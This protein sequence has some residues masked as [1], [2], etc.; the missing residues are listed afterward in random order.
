VSA[1]LRLT[2]SYAGFLVIAGIALIALVFYILQYV[3]DSG[4]LSDNGAFI[5]NRG[6]LLAAL[7][8]RT[9]QLIV[10]LALIGVVGGW[11]LAG[12]M[13]RPLDRINAVAR[14]VDAGAFDHRVHLRGRKDEFSELADTFD[15]M[16][17][18]L[19]GSFE[20]QRRFAANAAHELRTPYAIERSML[21]VAL[22][23][24]AHVD[25]D[26]LLR[27]LDETN[28]RG[29]EVVE[30]LLALASIDDGR[31]LPRSPVD[32]TETVAAVIRE[33][34]PLADAAGVTVVAELGECDIDGSPPLVR[35]LASNLILNGIRHNVEKDGWI[36]VRTT[37]ESD[38]AVEL[39]VSNSGPTVPPELLGR[40]TEP[41][42][43]GVSR[44]GT[45]ANSTKGSLEGTGLGLALVSRVA[46]VHGA[47]LALAAPETGGLIATVRFLA[48]G[49]TKSS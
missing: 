16:L 38:G 33:L 48:P 14:R 42:V 36:A 31:E 39:S 34:R 41:F 8:P 22:S 27:R 17:D 44:V 20:E 4:N 40:L 37:T 13:L 46:Q 32:A 2:L 5:P 43:R 45:R 1:R 29:I 35:Q 21:D 6:D 7:W 28:R 3:P 30:A 23:D 19:Q 26:Q 9:W 25:L 47:T 10:V 18:R 24:P 15:S 12:A 49:T 11:F